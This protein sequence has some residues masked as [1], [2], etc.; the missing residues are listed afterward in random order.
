[1]RTTGATGVEMEA[2]TAVSVA[3]LTIYDM[4]KAVDK[5]MVIGEIRL[6]REAGGGRSGRV[7]TATVNDPR[8]AFT[9]RSR[10]GPFRPSHVERLRARFP[11]HTLS[12][13]PQRRRRPV[14]LIAEAEVAFA[15]QIIAAAAAG[16][17]APALDA[18]PGGRR[19]RHAV[20][21]R[22]SPARSSSRTRAGMSADTIAEHV[23]AVTSRALPP[24]AARVRAPG[25]SATGRRTRLAPPAATARSPAPRV[26]VVGLGAHRQRRGA[27]MTLL[28]ARVTG[29]RRTAAGARPHGDVRRRRA[30]ADRAARSPAGRRRRRDRRAAHRDDAQHDRRAASWR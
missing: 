6:H 25:R 27:R 11:D 23:L 14:T 13:R 26:L 22:W 20:S 9:A 18:Q 3:A 8:L 4:V 1:M 2:L 29:A 17:A 15:G 19:R 30:A 28:G 16:G 21:R 10:C 7:D 12:P 24:A 5:A